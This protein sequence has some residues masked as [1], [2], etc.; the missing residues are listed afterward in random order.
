MDSC[1]IKSGIPPTINDDND[2]KTVFF[3][4]ATKASSDT[5]APQLAT[6]YLWAVKIEN[7]VDKQLGHGGN[8]GGGLEESWARSSYRA[9]LADYLAKTTPWQ[10]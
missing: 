7:T 6:F 3:I 10:V 1:P 8:G 2:P 4:N 5:V 9:K